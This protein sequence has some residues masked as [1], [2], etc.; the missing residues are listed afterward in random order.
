MVKRFLGQLDILPKQ[1]STKKAA[2]AALFEY[3]KITS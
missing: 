3:V 1:W 2:K